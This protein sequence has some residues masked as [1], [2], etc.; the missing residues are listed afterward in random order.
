MNTRKSDVQSHF[1]AL[2]DM[3]MGGFMTSE[4]DEMACLNKSA[5]TVCLLNGY[6]SAISP[7]MYERLMGAHC[8]NV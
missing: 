6:H 5:D 7:Y 1:H 3:D 2:N 8:T 4:F